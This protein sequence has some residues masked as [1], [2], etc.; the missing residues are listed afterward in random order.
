MFRSK[1][2]P[3]I[4]IGSMEQFRLDEPSFGY[5]SEKNSY[6]EIS[7]ISMDSQLTEMSDAEL[8]KWFKD[9]PPGANVLCAICTKSIKGHLIS[10]SRRDFIIILW[11]S[12]RLFIIRTMSFPANVGFLVG[13]C[14]VLCNVQ[15][16]S[17][18]API[19]YEK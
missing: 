14:N 6:F 1:S 8:R 4:T 18:N 19:L 15:R 2:L 3:A 5:N 7:T 17:K 9:L 11:L 12:T 16:S 13:A 10:G